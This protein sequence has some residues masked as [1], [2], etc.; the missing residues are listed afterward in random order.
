MPWD[1][2][3]HV[4]PSVS[5]FETTS[6]LTAWTN[7]SRAGYAT[8][9]GDTSAFGKRF[10]RIVSRA[11]AGSRSAAAR[12]QRSRPAARSMRFWHVVRL[13]RAG[14]R[15][16]VAGVVGIVQDGSGNTCAFGKPPCQ[17]S[18]DVAFHPR[19]ASPAVTFLRLDWQPRCGRRPRR[20][21]ARRNRAKPSLRQRSA[22]VDPHRR[23]YQSTAR[24]TDGRAR[25]G[26]R[27]EPAL[28]SNARL[29]AGSTLAPPSY[30]LSGRSSI[31]LPSTRRRTSPRRPRRGASFTPE[32]D[33]QPVV[34][35]LQRSHSRS[36]HT[37]YRAPDG[38]TPLETTS[39]AA[40][41]LATARPV[42][43]PHN[44]RSARRNHPK[45]SRIRPRLLLW[46]PVRWSHVL[47]RGRYLRKTCAERA[48]ASAHDLHGDAA[49]RSV[50]VMGAKKPSPLAMIRRYR[51]VVSSSWSIASRSAWSAPSAPW[52]C[53]DSLG[54]GKGELGP[55]LDEGF[56]ATI[57]MS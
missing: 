3:S 49:V 23:P 35:L 38:G 21:S 41:Q 39:G 6:S 1:V 19:M 20:T 30:S 27:R 57:T 44:N 53:C 33:N 46:A 14:H 9:D 31:P 5:D 29:G 34:K 16:R 52:Y 48:A 32:P 37:V 7:S 56:V 25:W 28:T 43:G 26:S 12:R 42:R 40:N 10:V 13:G 36:V 24:M 4:M 2:A 45:L 47:D 50:L 11:L 17:R 54:L 55:E 8:A 51:V 18:V 15:M 22:P